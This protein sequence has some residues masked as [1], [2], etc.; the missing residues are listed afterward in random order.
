VDDVEDRRV[1]FVCGRAREEGPADAQVNA[2]A[3]ALRDERVRGLLDAIVQEGVGATLMD[4]ESRRGGL[5]E[6]CID[7]RLGSPASRSE[8]PRRR[9]VSQARELL[10]G[11]ARRRR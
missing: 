7:G 8:H 9:A 2:R 4:D 3:V 11:I 1:A 6:R 5:G 10:Q